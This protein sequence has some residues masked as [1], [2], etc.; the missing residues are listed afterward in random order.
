MSKFRIILLAAIHSTL[1]T[2]LPAQS[3]LFRDYSTQ[4]GLPDSRIAPIIQD[5][6]GYIWFGAQAGLTRYDGNEFVTFGQA[7]DIPGIFGRSIMEDRFGA[8]WFAC[9]GFRTGSLTRYWHDSVLT[10]DH[11]NGLMGLQPF[12]VV[13]GIENDV[14]VGTE[15]GIERIRF[16][17]STRTRWTVDTW[18]DSSL[19][20]LYRKRTGVLYFADARGL[21]KVVDDRPVCIFATGQN[22]KRWHVRPY[23]FFERMTGTSS[24]GASARRTSFV[25]I[26]C[27]VSDRSTESRKG[28]SG[29]FRRMWMARSM[30]ERWLDSIVLH[31]PDRVS[32]S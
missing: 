5:R 12:D 16:L 17:D 32:G 19:T 7:H 9:S 31:R 1:I 20:A 4:D 14:W 26:R 28:G 29:V 3:L 25:T 10:I 8:I 15:A 2:L 22:D 13:D 27:T 18:K 6:R 11:S 21:F 23:S 30:P 24:L